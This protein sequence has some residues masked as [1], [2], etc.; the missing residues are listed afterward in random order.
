MTEQK[1]QRVFGGIMLA[2]TMV[3]AAFL[4]VSIRADPGLSVQRLRPVLLLI[5]L[6]AQGF[7]LLLTGGHKGLVNVLRAIAFI[8]VLLSLAMWFIP[9]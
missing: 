5:G 7:A 3:S 2:L 9:Q 8:A 1:R 4:L 6:L